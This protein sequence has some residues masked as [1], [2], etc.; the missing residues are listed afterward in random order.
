MPVKGTVV[1]LQGC[2]RDKALAYVLREAASGPE[3]LVFEHEGRPQAGMQVPAGTV[4]AG[5]TPMQA[6]VRELA[7]ESG[8]TVGGRPT[9]VGTF[10][11]FHPQKQEWHRRHVFRFEAPEGLPAGW[12]HVVSGE[13]KD[14]GRRFRYFWCDARVAETTLAGAQGAYL[15]AALDRPDADTGRITSRLDGLAR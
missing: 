11:H 14:R 8:L 2:I 15:R 3:V 10:D 12:T 1:V 7:E 4:D 6:A 13:G 5:E 9:E